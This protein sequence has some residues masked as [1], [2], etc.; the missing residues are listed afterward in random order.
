[1]TDKIEAARNMLLRFSDVME[2]HM[3]GDGY[4]VTVTLSSGKQV[5]GAIHNPR[6]AGYVQM[7]VP[8]K[9]GDPSPVFIALGEIAVIEV[10]P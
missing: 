7:D 2:Q 3:D 4:H 6:M 10:S 8:D 9:K 5:T 1:M